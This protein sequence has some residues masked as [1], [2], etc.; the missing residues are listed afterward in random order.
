MNYYSNRKGGLSNFQRVSGMI[1]NNNKHNGRIRINK[2]Y[3]NDFNRF[4][5]GN[6]KNNF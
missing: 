1:L 6:N 5:Y 3:G 2:N 4:R